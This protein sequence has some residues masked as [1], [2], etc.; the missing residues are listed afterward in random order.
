MYLKT[1]AVSPKP[2]LC[3][4]AL[5]SKRVLFVNVVNH[6]ISLIQETLF[7]IGIH[8]DYKSVDKWVSVSPVN[9]VSIVALPVFQSRASNQNRVFGF[10][11]V[12]S[13]S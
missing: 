11:Q 6:S 3:S 4:G 9:Y 7:V 12:K 1:K 13:Y 8:L 2:N 10:R 5:T